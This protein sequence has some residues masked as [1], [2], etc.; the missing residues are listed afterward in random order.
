DYWRKVYRYEVI[1]CC[2][3]PG[4]INKQGNRKVV[5]GQKGGPLSR[6]YFCFRAG[7]ASKALA[8]DMKVAGPVNSFPTILIFGSRSSFS[9][10][11]NWRN[12][13]MALATSSCR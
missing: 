11:T 4:I 13:A 7:I 9:L 3:D 5:A 10:V 1:S 12:S 2:P 8:S 6:G